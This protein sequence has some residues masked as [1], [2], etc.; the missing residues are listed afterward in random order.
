MLVLPL[1]SR[2]WVGAWWLFCSMCSFETSQCEFKVDV[3]LK[4]LHMSQSEVSR[5]SH[6][7]GSKIS[8]ISLEVR[9]VQ[10]CSACC[11]CSFL[12][13]DD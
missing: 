8:L 11:P 1:R 5:H 13:V 3:S 7:P 6:S 9:Q 12:E 4:E 2:P 10:G